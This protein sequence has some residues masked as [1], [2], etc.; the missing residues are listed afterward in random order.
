MS[1]KDTEVMDLVPFEQFDISD[2]NVQDLIQFNLGG[3][4]FGIMDLD[5]ITIPRESQ[6]FEMP[7]GESVKEFQGIIFHTSVIR[8][9]YD[10]AYNPDETGPPTCFSPDGINGYGEPALRCGGKCAG[11]PLSKFGSV[12]NGKA[13]ACKQY[14]LLCT[15]LPDSGGV[16]TIINVP[17]TSLKR[18]KK[19]LSQT[20]GKLHKRY[21]HVI[22]RFTL[23]KG[24]RN[25]ELQMHYAGDVT[26][27]EA[28]DAYAKIMAPSM[29]NAIHEMATQMNTDNGEDFDLLG[30]ISTDDSPGDES[31]A[32]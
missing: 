11:C 16:P 13:Q 14:R 26:D 30:D 19:Y 31:Q 17:P 10:S 7:D 5:R 21:P 4:S 1:K 6:Y 27:K 9:Y 2:G 18:A 3:D 23:E 32:F 29:T 22:T 15:V 12:N 25:Y 28:V 8:R 24:K 20:L